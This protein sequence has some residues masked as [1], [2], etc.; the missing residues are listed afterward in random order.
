MPG[1]LLDEISEADEVDRGRRTT[2]PGELFDSGDEFGSG[3]EDS[4]GG[5][6]GSAAFA[7]T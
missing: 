5:C 7:F 6:F 2:I 4:F 3:S 1:A